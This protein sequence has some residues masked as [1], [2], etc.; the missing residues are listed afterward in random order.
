MTTALATPAAATGVV[1]LRQGAVLARPCDGYPAGTTA[2]VL[3][4]RQ[5]CA[6]VRPDAAAPVAAWARPRRTLHVPVRLLIT[7]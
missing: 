6:V 3:G 1:P 7:A 5:G 4:F 2:E